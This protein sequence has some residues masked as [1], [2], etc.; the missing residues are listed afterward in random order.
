MRVKAVMMLF[1]NADLLLGR[2]IADLDL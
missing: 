1:E 2:G